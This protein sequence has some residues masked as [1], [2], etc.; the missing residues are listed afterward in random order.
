MC[1]ESYFAKY[2]FW[3]IKNAV[4]A[5]HPYSF[6]Q[7]V[8]DAAYFHIIGSNDVN[9]FISGILQNLFIEIFSAHG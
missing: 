3:K 5:R 6:T 4:Y 8:R 2:H 9:I 1:D 7:H